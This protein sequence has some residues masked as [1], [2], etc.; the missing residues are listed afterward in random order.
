MTRTPSP[1]APA[2]APSPGLAVIETNAEDIDA[3]RVADRRGQLAFPEKPLPLRRVVNGAIEQLERNPASAGGLLR[4]VHLA[5]AA[6]AEQ[7]LDLVRSE[8]LAGHQQSIARVT[9]Q[10]GRP[11]R[12]GRHRQGFGCVV[13]R[14]AGARSAAV[15]GVPVH[16]AT[17]WVR[18]RREGVKAARIR[19][20]VEV[21]IH[22]VQR[23]HIMRT[24]ATQRPA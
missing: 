5:H 7:A 24:V 16:Q 2:P 21:A 15:F 12:I 13:Y 1:T 6:A 18:D 20:I 22:V 14:G 8:A 23:R 9:R 17:P 4:L 19:R 10:G 11:A 3:A